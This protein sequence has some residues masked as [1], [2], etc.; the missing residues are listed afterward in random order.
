MAAILGVAYHH[1]HL[2]V[3]GAFVLFWAVMVF[4][5]LR[6]A[7]DRPEG[8]LIGRAVKAGVLA[9]IIM[10]ASWAAAFGVTYLA[11]II[12]LLLPLSILLARAF[13]VT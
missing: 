7:V 5:P 13:A 2:L 9:L 1:G 12:I 8:K 3:A 6:K 10:N 11:L 4:T